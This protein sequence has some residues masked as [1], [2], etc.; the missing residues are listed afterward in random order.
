MFLRFLRPKCRLVIYSS[1]I[2]E[3]Q[4]MF[5]QTPF[6]DS[7]VVRSAR[8]MYIHVETR[9]TDSQITKLQAPVL[10]IQ[11]PYLSAWCINKLILQWLDGKRKITF[12]QVRATRD[13]PRNEVFHG[14][15]PAALI[16]GTEASDGR[17]Y[18]PSLYTLVRSDHGDL[19]VYLDTD[20][21]N[22]SDPFQ[23]SH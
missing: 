18:N 15:E 22:I 20:Y 4:K 14:I 19:V 5:L 2:S 16:T 6:F 12:V 1:G 9:I 21:C 17:G 8:D 23:Y 11:S 10:R 13:L 7:D 3:P